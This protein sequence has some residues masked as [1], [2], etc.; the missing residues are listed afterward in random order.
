VS[1]AILHLVAVILGLF[2]LLKCPLS[3][4]HRL[5]GLPFRILSVL[6]RGMVKRKGIIWTGLVWWSFIAL[7]AS[8]IVLGGGYPWMFK[9]KVVVVSCLPSAAC[10]YLRRYLH[11]HRHQLPRR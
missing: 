4:W 6:I 9:L 1:D 10:W 5:I 2:L 8:L 7:V 11:K 3:K